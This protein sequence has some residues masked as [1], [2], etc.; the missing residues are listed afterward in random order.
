LKRLAGRADAPAAREVALVVAHP[1][2]ETIGAGAQFPH[3]RGLTVVHV[4]DGA[5]RNGADATAYGFALPGSYAAARR[6]EVEA[7]LACAG[8]GTEALVG[9]GVPDQEASLRL[10]EVA[11]ALVRIFSERRIQLVLTHAYEGGHPDHD[12]VAFAVHA[13][14]RL[15]AASTGERIGIVEMPFYRADG[16]GWARQRFMPDPQHP[17]IAIPL[18]EADRALKRRMLD[19]HETQRGALA[20]FMLDCERFRAAPDYDFSEPPNG[21]QLLYERY[22]W[23]MTGARWRE[24]AQRA[25]A[26]LGLEARRCA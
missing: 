21:G 23:G 10:A 22:P 8:V 17:E 19:A 5:P 9:L 7:A 2:D 16:S 12:A 13:A 6:R 26:E 1:D 25:L 24:L 20:P 15:L 18:S 3:L 4:T 11:H 14:R